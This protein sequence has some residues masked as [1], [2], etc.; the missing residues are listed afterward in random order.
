MGASPALSGF[1]PSLSGGREACRTYT[2][3]FSRPHPSRRPGAGQGLLAGRLGGKVDKTRSHRA[4]TAVPAAACAARTMRV[5]PGAVLLP[6][7][8]LLLPLAPRTHGLAP[9]PRGEGAVGGGWALDDW[10]LTSS[11]GTGH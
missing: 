10:S 2:A 4:S 7:L 9:Q 6:C 11:P 1:L 3:P 8:L 5:I